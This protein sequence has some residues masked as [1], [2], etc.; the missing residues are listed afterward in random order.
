MA[1]EDVEMTTMATLGRKNDVTAIAA[2]D[3]GSSTQMFVPSWMEAHYNTVTAQIR[4]LEEAV[5]LAHEHQRQLDQD[6]PGLIAQCHSMLAYQ[7]QLYDDACTGVQE[8]R[9]T[10][11]ARRRSFQHFGVQPINTYRSQSRRRWLHL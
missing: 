7:N 4:Q 2:R 11:Y 5:R 8:V 6:Y 9:R 1:P 10:Q 3:N